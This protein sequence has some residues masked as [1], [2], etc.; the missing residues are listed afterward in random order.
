[1]KKLTAILLGSLLF[2]SGAYAQT[3]CTA[4][5]L[6]N[7]TCRDSSGTTSHTATDY[8]GNT[9]TRD[10]RG[11]VIRG[12]TDYFGLCRDSCGTD[13]IMPPPAPTMDCAASA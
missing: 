4:D 13:L 6:G 5:Y 8:F 2:S 10:N 11:N 9:T 3:R 7:T 12:S 1:M